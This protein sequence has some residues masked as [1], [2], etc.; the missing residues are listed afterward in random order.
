M[1]RFGKKSFMALSVAAALSV[2]IGIDALD[3]AFF[4]GDSGA[5]VAQERQG[6][7]NRGGRRGFDPDNM[8][9][10]NFE[11][12]RNSPF[13]ERAKEMAGAERWAQWE[14]GEFIAGD[15]AEEAANAQAKQDGTAEE[16]P[17]LTP[18]EIAD[19]ESRLT[20][21]TVPEF[22]S[23]G[24]KR[25]S[26]ET[27]ADYYRQAMARQDDVL[28]DSA[29]LTLRFYLR[30][31]LNKY[32]S[33]GD[34][35]LQREEWENRLEG[36]QA[37]DLNGDWDLTDQEVLYY[38]TRF[39]EGRSIFNPDPVRL[40]RNRVNF[41][42]DDKEKETLIRPASAA[43][44]R[45][46]GEEAE[47]A[48]KINDGETALAELSGEE[49]RDMFKEGSPALES[50]DDEEM[51]DALLADM[52][53]SNVREYAASPQVLRGVPVWFLARDKNGDG[54]LTLLEFAPQLSQRLIALFGRYDAD[55]DQLITAEEAKRGP[56]NTQQ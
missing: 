17:N 46:S 5:A 38:L 24:E 43:P 29:P 34:G 20:A 31:L 12:I 22:V 26:I 50:V 3:S 56:V 32:D 19:A 21:G 7:G 47:E 53:E 27:E 4:G 44:K 23:E 9:R 52:D 2:T 51:L 13:A 28:I 35:V 30:H 48:R 25:Y 40:T 39:A 55:G 16:I 11:R 14:R 49:V 42:T 15:P 33:N 41:I 36:A 8:T 37:M 18:E 10:E 54:Q 1:L 6:R 45:L